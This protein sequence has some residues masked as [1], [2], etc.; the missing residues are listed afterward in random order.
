MRLAGE[1]D[2]TTR[3][4]WD[5]LSAEAAKEPRVL[6]ID[7]SELTFMDSAA[8]HAIVRAYRKLRATG[9]QLALVS[10]SPPVARLL[11]LSGLDTVIDV[12][13]SAEDVG[14]AG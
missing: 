11:Q 6:L 1:A 5:T 3:Q 12:H 13:A 2:V 7:V 14:P 10:P 8:L 9:G 4:L